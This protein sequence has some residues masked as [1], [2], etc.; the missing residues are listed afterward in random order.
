MT[1]QET[2]TKQEKLI[3]W[4]TERLEKVKGFWGN[5]ELCGEDYIK[6]AEKELEEVKNGRS[7]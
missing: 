3:L 6:H 4:Y 5:D 1:K 7:W 2:I